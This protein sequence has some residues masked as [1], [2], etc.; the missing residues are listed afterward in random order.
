MKFLDLFAGIGGWFS[1]S[2]ILQKK[3]RGDCMNWKKLVALNILFAL[4]IVNVELHLSVVE[5]LLAGVAIGL[6]SQDK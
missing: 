3:K 2:A 1:R 5:K 6:L 4:L